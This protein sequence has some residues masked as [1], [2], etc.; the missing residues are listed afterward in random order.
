MTRVELVFALAAWDEVGAARRPRRAR[1]GGAM[2]LVA[3]LRGHGLAV[4]TQPSFVAARGDQSLAD[5]DAADRP[6]CGAAGRC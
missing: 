4:V 1:R 2:D 6:P 5:V 3:A